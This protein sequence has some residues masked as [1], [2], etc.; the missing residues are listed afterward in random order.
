[1]D[2]F[3]VL[4]LVLMWS[5]WMS[6]GNV[7][8][9][10]E[11]EWILLAAAPSTSLSLHETIPAGSTA[12]VPGFQKELQ[13]QRGA[14]GQSSVSAFLCCVIA[15]CNHAPAALKPKSKVVSIVESLRHTWIALLPC[16]S[17]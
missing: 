11:V 6:V 16:I 7:F 10:R 12:T 9:S 8:E 1:M 3:G 13:M 15:A 2:I 17:I 14:V 5:V 4:L